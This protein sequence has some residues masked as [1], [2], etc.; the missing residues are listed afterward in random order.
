MLAWPEDRRRT[1]GWPA[2]GQQEDKRRTKAGKEKDKLRTQCSGAGPEEEK[3]RTRGDTLF[4]FFLS[5][6]VH[7]SLAS[8]LCLL[9]TCIFFASFDSLASGCLLVLSMSFLVV[10]CWELS[11]FLTCLH[12]LLLCSSSSCATLF[13]GFLGYPCVALVL[14][15][16]LVS[17]LSLVCLVSFCR[18]FY[19]PRYFLTLAIVFALLLPFWSFSCLIV[20]VCSWLVLISFKLIYTYASHYM[21]Y[22]DPQGPPSIQACYTLR[23]VYFC[24]LCFY[25]A[26]VT[27]LRL[28]PDPAPHRA[29][30]RD[31]RRSSSGAPSQSG[32]VARM[33][34]FS[35]G[36]VKVRRPKD[37]L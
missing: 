36:D 37:G 35:L 10:V 20:F 15:S 7:T 33:V 6:A 14:F 2:G 8:S 25:T 21:L 30:A 31:A 1:Q 29:V 19:F 26:F 11:F 28:R 4:L 18:S 16:C 23:N 32:L 24:A 34:P 17:Y 27:R 9:F 22:N 3:R 5:F 13:K 12:S